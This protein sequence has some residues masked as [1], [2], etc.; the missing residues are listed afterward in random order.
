MKRDCPKSA[1]ILQI[2]DELIIQAHRTE[3]EKV[4]RLLEDSMKGAAE[5]TVTMDV[6]LN[7]GENWYLLK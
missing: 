1:L 5:L 4:R 2:H 7:E 6:S 3:T